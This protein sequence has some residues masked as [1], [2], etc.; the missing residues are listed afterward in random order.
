MTREQIIEAIKTSVN[1]D[2]GHAK[3]VISDMKEDSR[4]GILSID[5]ENN[6]LLELV[7]K[8]GHEEWAFP[9]DDKGI[10]QTIQGSM[11]FD[12]FIYTQDIINYAN[13]I[14]KKYKLCMIDCKPY[15]CEKQ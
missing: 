13:E 8:T 7:F 5:I 2:F 9:T 14:F 12:D 3:E 1:N 11:H 10:A 6:E 4:D 15:E